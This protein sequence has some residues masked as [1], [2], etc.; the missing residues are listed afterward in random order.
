[1]MLSRRMYFALSIIFIAVFSVFFYSL[2]PLSVY[3]QG[4]NSLLNNST[5]TKNI[6]FD[7]LIVDK[8]GSIYLAD[9]LNHYI[10]K[11]DGNGKFISSWGSAGKGFGHFSGP[12]AITSDRYGSIFVA[13]S[14]NNRIQ[15]FDGNGK[16]I[17]SWGSNGKGIGQFIG[18]LLITMDAA[19]NILVLD[20][21]TNIIQKFDGGGKF[22]A[23]INDIPDAM[24]TSKN[25]LTTAGGGNFTLGVNIN[26]YKNFS[27]VNAT[28]ITNPNVP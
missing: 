4:S 11:L 1:M 18:Q 16:F 28:P 22:L 21:G 17:T 27:I 10:L 14:N 8:F 24:I 3:S 5:N 19:N 15:K 20:K 6:S 7:N 2:Y 12:M 23:L 25:N 9:S 13:D 26:Q